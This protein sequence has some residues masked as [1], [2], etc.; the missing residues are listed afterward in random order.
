MSRPRVQI[1]Y[2]EGCPNHEPALAL[3]ERIAAELG[4]QPDVELVPVLDA[5]AA[6]RLRFLGSPTLRVDGLDV[7][8][9]AERRGDFVF[10]CRVYRNEHGLSGRPDEGWIREALAKAAA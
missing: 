4:V 2:F 1:L 6:T 7:E 3:V 9:G 10:S 5:D 8:C